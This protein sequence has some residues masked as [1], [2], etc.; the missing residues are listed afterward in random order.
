MENDNFRKKKVSFVH[1]PSFLVIENSLN[2][3]ELPFLYIML[4]QPG[5][6]VTGSLIR[7]TEDIHFTI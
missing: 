5:Q 1:S 7:S 2:S 3:I 6:M 4:R